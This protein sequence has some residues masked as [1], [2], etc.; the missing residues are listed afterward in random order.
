MKLARQINATSNNNGNAQVALCD[1][2]T[3]HLQKL[4]YPGQSLWLK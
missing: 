3:S 1:T 4:L 2:F